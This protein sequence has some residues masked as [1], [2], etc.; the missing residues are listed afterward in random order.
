M[1]SEQLTV[2]VVASEA[3]RNLAYDIR[4]RV[5]VNE[6]HVPAD[7][8]FDADDERATHVL[9]CIGGTPVGTGRVVFHA[10]YAKIGR[11]AV[12]QKWRRHGVGRA[13]MQAL[14]DIGT[15]GKV[16]RFV[17][18]AQVQA[19]PF[20]ESLGFTV[21]SEEFEEAGIPHRQMEREP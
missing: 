6:Q 20:Y 11:M 2:R 3:E 4:R 1:S 14:M 21:T 12:V 7:E 18:H 16:C 19:L 5:F 15:Q 13:V 9:A 17:L 8:E 10:D